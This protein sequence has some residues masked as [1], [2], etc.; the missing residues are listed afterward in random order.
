[1]ADQMPSGTLQGGSYAEKMSLA[2]F[3][4]LAEH[5]IEMAKSDAKAMGIPL[6]RSTPEIDAKVRRIVKASGFHF[7]ETERHV[8]VGIKIAATSLAMLGAEPDVIN[9][10]SLLRV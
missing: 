3:S 9:I 7:S 5:W 4:K 10:Q 8:E 1:M 2:E 6:R